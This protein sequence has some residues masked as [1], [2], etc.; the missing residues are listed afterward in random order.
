MNKIEQL[1]SDIEKIEK[2]LNS[3]TTPE[4]FKEPLR[5][6]LKG[7]K[8]ELESLMQEKKEAPKKQEAPVKKAESV[9]KE[10]TGKKAGVKSSKILEDCKKI[11]SKHNKEKKSAVERIK[12][13]KKQGKPAKLTP[14]ETVSK[15]A[16]S[17]KS[18]IVEM[19]DKTDNGLPMSEVHK[20]SN[21][22]VA[23]VKS[24]L[25][26]IK[27]NVE[28]REFINNLISEIRSLS[29]SLTKVAMGGGMFEDGGGLDLL[30]DTDGATLQ[31]V[32][33]TAFSNADLTP[34]MDITNPMF[35]DGGMM[36]KG[37]GISSV[38]ISNFNKNIMGTLSFDMKLENMRKE[39]D[40]IV[41]PISKGDTQIMIQSDTRIGRI[42]MASGNGK[43]SQSHPN[44]AYGVHLQMDNL[45]PF[46]L[47]PNQL[48]E[49]KA[50]LSKTAGKNV[51]SSVVLSD[52]EGANDFMEKGGR[53]NTGRSWTL[54][55]NQ[56]N[57]SEKYERPIKERKFG[58]GGINMDEYF[59]KKKY[60]YEEGGIADSNTEMLMSTIRELKHHTTEIEKL[61]DSNTKVEAWVVA[62]AE[63]S[64]TD[65]SDITHYIDGKK[66]TEV[67]SEKLEHGGKLASVDVIFENPDYNYSTSINPDASEEEV[68]KYFVGNMFDM[69]VYPSE[70]FQKVI[71]IKHNPSKNYDADGGMMAKGG[72]IKVGDI[73]TANTGV[74]V[75][76]VAYDPNF[77][78]RVKVERQDE[79]GTGEISQYMPLSRFKMED[80]GMM[81]KGGK[82]S[83][84]LIHKVHG[85]EYYQDDILIEPTSSQ[86]LFWELN[87][88]PNNIVKKEQYFETIIDEYSDKSKKEVAQYFDENLKNGKYNYV[89]QNP[90]LYTSFDDKMADG[91]T[92]GAG[93]FADGG[94]TGGMM[95]AFDLN[96]EGNFAAEID[97]KKYEII[98]RDDKS[99]MYDLFEDG[100]KIKSSRAVIDVMN[101]ADGGTLGAGSYADG[102]MT[103]GMTAGR[104]YKDKSGAEFRFLGRKDSGTNEGKLVFNDGT[105]NVYKT[106]D[107]FGS[108]PKEKKLFGIFE[109]GG[110][111]AKKGVSKKQPLSAAKKIAS[112]MKKK[113]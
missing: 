52:N 35:E 78:G 9:K 56:H 67:G 57:K 62:K 36:A 91:G 61:V 100:K 104:W 103:G 97:G 94:M 76:V 82:I 109:K 16:K 74:K 81:A 79:Y 73:L 19:K 38:K 18:K 64:A 92:L 71:D 90:D 99:K 108:V 55:R 95:A 22:I 24:T 98:Y 33:G 87:E 6:T 20:L 42:D 69:G 50:E 83:G 60:S 72:E 86:K 4:Q 15:T 113:S 37:G 110:K 85:V 34:L 14:S 89:G 75:K 112:A 66:T 49:L 96:P 26:G 17:V 101:F 25:S 68:R 10:V 88:L 43:M 46:Q 63:R 28:K 45:V 8:D 54:D 93:S 23:T 77:G 44:G 106:L 107:D 2:G 21:G 80:G 105:S 1:K 59:K 102:G 47:E 53:Y 111:T 12:E 31:N 11:L 27:N 58:E 7:K 3:S 65:L 70:N 40:F 13:R 39:Q 84:K 29:N 32:G 5:K 48:S 30:A 51:G 41:Y